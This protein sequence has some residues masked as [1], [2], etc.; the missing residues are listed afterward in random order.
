M[1]LLQEAGGSKKSR[2][3]GKQASSQSAGCEFMRS[4]IKMMLCVQECLQN[5]LQFKSDLSE[6]EQNLVKLNTH[7]YSYIQSPLV[8]ACVQYM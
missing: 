1:H 2:K 7:L 8:P 4:S 5:I 6:S 3:R